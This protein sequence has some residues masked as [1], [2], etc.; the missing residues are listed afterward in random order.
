MVLDMTRSLSI[1]ENETKI[2]DYLWGWRIIPLSEDVADETYGYRSNHFE[3]RHR[4]RHVEARE[5]SAISATNRL[6]AFGSR[7]IRRPA[8]G[9][10]LAI[11]S[12]RTGRSRRRHV[13]NQRQKSARSCDRR[14]ACQAQRGS[15]KSS[16]TIVSA[17][18]SRSSTAS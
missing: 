14:K 6:T 18:R 7:R 13:S 3:G 8:L 12:M 5:A 11:A 2:E 10:C 17:A 16:R 4:P 1:L 9:A 15:E